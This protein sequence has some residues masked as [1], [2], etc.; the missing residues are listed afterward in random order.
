MGDDGL[1]PL[2]KIPR[3]PPTVQASGAKSGAV[4]GDYNTELAQVVAAWPELPADARHEI[5]AI[6]RTKR[7]PKESTPER[8]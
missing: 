4:S 6:V 5:F 7:G 3:K 2:P 8:G 1:E